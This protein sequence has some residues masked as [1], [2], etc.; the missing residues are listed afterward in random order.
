GAV[1]EHLS[2]VTVLA[3]N[4]PV[5]RITASKTGIETL[6]ELDFVWRDDGTRRVYHWELATKFY[7]L[8]DV[9]HTQHPDIPTQISWEQ[10]VGPNLADRFGDKL[11][12]I[13]ERQ[14]LL[15]QTPEARVAL[16]CSVDEA[17]AYLK[18]WLFYP[19]AQ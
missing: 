8:A 3:A 5:R 12:H 15:S 11:R 9:T 10:F 7:L 14:L 17:A 2:G 4:L 19:L 18:G 13:A 16:G 1:L 6:G